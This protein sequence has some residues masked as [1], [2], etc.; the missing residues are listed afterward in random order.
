MT[1]TEAERAL[2]GFDDVR[3][4]PDRRLKIAARFNDDQ[5]GRAPIR[6]YR[7]AELAFMRWQIRR[8]VL[9]PMSSAQPGSEWWRA[10]NERLLRD[11]FEA[12]HLASGAPGS[13]SRSPVKRWTNFLRA[14]SPQ[15]WYRAHNASIVAGYL[16][17]RHLAGTS[18]IGVPQHGHRNPPSTSSAERLENVRAAHAGQRIT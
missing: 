18:S 6:G 13:P 14:P 2:R 16:E 9:A 15:S 17:H 7:R 8:G 5:P 1:L 12:G 3:D 10:L 4:H 11:A